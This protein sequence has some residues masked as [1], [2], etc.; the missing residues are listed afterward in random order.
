MSDAGFEASPPSDTIRDRAEKCQKIVDDKMGILRR[1]DI[2]RRLGFADLKEGGHARVPLQKRR[3]WIKL[4]YLRAPS[5]L[6]Q[7][8]RRLPKGGRL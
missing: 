2:L 8:A 1:T 4:W 3:P 7:Y 5:R 6:C